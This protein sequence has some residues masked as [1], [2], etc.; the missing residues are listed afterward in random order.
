MTILHRVYTVKGI[1]KVS[2]SRIPPWETPYF[3]QCNLV[4]PEVPMG[5]NAVWQKADCVLISTN[6]VSGP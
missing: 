3:L 6:A 1:I 5:G 2:P 4:T